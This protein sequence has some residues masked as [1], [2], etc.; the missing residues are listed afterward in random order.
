MLERT[1]DNKE[2]SHQIQHNQVLRVEV[3]KSNESTQGLQR[4]S[5]RESC[6]IIPKLTEMPPTWHV[7]S[8]VRVRAKRTTSEKIFGSKWK[9]YTKVCNG[10]VRLS[11]ESSVQNFVSISS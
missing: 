11:M 4:Y 8:Y 1:S 10:K 9:I 7:I 2:K 3:Q 5:G 6:R